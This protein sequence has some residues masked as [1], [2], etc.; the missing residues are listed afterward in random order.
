MRTHTFAPLRIG[1]TV[2]FTAI[3]IAGLCAL[4]PTARAQGGAFGAPGE[5]V[6]TGDF[7]GH[8]VKGYELRLHPSLDYFIAPNV[9]VGGVVGLTYHSGDPSTTTVDLGARAGYN[10]GIT[11]QVSFWPMVGIFY[12]H[13]SV[14]NNMGGGSSTVLA[15]NAPFLFHIVPHFFVGA[16]PFFDLPLDSGGNNYGL[17]TVVGGWF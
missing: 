4:S 9:S 14:S 12:S 15:I 11:P 10:L 7:E 1:R 2:V 6:I 16:G 3:L 13:T 17:Q 5:F 8:L